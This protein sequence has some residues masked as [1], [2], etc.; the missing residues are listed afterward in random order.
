MRK[1]FFL[2]GN[3]ETVFIP[4]ASL[5]MFSEQ[6]L[7]LDGK[8]II[9]AIHLYSSGADLSSSA[10][11]HSAFL[12]MRLSSKL[13]KRRSVKTF[14]SAAF[15]TFRLFVFTSSVE[16]GVLVPR[17]YPPF[18]TSRG[19]A[20]EIKVR[21]NAVAVQD[22]LVMRSPPPFVDSIPEKIWYSSQKSSPTKPEIR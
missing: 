21:G 17:A 6:K 13:S 16:N 7:A 1:A 15:I 8:L 12:S 10:Q 11:F 14:V 4:T 9:L 2:Y 22:T 19:Q 5:V 20:T 3:N 18:W